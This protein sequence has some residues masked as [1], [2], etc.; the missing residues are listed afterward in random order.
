[1]FLEG[2]KEKGVHDNRPSLH[3]K[4]LKSSE[5]A[6]NIK[7]GE[8]STSNNKWGRRSGDLYFTMEVDDDGHGPFPTC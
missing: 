8:K 7:C 5:L 6:I 2:T 3:D 4:N 1:M